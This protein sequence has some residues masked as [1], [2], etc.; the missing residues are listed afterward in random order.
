[1]ASSPELAEF[2]EQVARAV[3]EPEYCLFGFQHWSTCMTKAAWSS[4]V[5]AGVSMLAIG[6]AL[7]A[8]VI[9]HAL[10]A[11]AERHAREERHLDMIE[12]LRSRLHDSQ[13]LDRL[14]DP[15]GFVAMVGDWRH[16]TALLDIPLLLKHLAVIG[17]TPSIGSRIGEMVPALRIAAEGFLASANHIEA[18]YR[19]GEVM[20][21]QEIEATIQAAQ[22]FEQTA[23][24]CVSFLDREIARSRR[25]L[26]QPNPS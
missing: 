13:R 1:M 18:K 16:A 12:L 14:T 24:V 4:W 21:A 7:L 23:D 17:E 22:N 19:S 8:V 9:Q 20:N 11:R 2:A 26:K 5:Q 15:N 3:A 25:R 10:S 6:A